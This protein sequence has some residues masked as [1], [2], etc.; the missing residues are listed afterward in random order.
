MKC[1]RSRAQETGALR[2]QVTSI[3]LRPNIGT[4]DLDV[5]AVIRAYHGWSVVGGLPSWKQNEALAIGNDSPGFCLSGEISLFE[6]IVPEILC[7]SFFGSGV[8][9]LI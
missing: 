1:D 2:C 3:C 8:C 7:C 4:R 6:C 5:I 9:F